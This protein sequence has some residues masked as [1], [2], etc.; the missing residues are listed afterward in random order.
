[1][2]Q[3]VGTNP[4]TLLLFTTLFQIRKYSSL[5]F[6]VIT[7]TARF[8]NT[9]HQNFSLTIILIIGALNSYDSQGRISKIYYPFYALI[10]ANSRIDINLL[11]RLPFIYC[12]TS[13]AGHI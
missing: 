9:K 13:L 10:Y 12:Y 1:M 3:S 8:Y 6:K 5:R 4:Y 7:V 2:L 11:L